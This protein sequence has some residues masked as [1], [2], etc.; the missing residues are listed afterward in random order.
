MKTLYK[1]GTQTQNYTQ[2]MFLKHY[3]TLYK[4]GT[5]SANCTKILHLYPYG[6][7][8]HAPTSPNSSGC[9]LPAKTT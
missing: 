2:L 8:L 1:S 9:L 7:K 6:S 3:G 4:I 5:Q